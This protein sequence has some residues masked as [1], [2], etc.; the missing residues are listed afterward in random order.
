MPTVLAGQ[1]TIGLELEQQVPDLDTLFVSVGGGGLIGGISSW[2]GGRVNVVAVESEGT[3]TYA[4]ALAHG[5]DAEISPDGIAK[6]SLGGPRL[7]ALAYDALTLG[8]RRSIVVRDTQIIQ[9]Q[10]R[11]WDSARIFGEPGAATA[12]AALTSGAYQ[13]EVGERIG[14]LICGANAAPDWFLEEN[15]A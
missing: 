9:A 14:V 4:N 15:K 8:N 7:G 11:L 3:A 10:Q 6:G 13:P 1:G 2:F 5:K 12:V